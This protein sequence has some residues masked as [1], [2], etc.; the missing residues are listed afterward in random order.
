MTLCEQRI[1]PMI[2]LAELMPLP[3][4]RA[5]GEQVEPSQPRRYYMGNLYHA[6]GSCNA[7]V[8]RL[9]EKEHA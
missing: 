9:K 5:C 3:K 6:T 4:C 7:L 8:E 2:D 1:E